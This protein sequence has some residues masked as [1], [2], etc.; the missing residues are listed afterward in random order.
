MQHAIGHLLLGHCFYG[1]YPNFFSGIF[2]RFPGSA[3]LSLVF[4]YFSP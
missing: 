4:D 2:S 1:V 3:A